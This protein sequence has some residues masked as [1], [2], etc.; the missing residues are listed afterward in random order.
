MG[1]QLLERYPIR[2]RHRERKPQVVAKFLLLRKGK[3]LEQLHC[4]PLLSSHAIGKTD[5][6]GH[7]L[8][9]MNL[10]L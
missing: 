6:K 7:P 1:K 4:L 2:K 8:E 3:K 5:Y 9:V 10:K